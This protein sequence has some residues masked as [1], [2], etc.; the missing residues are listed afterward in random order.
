MDKD[1]ELMLAPGGTMMSPDE[2]ERLKRT[3]GDLA[4]RPGLLG[5]LLF[6][7]RGPTPHDA[8]PRSPQGPGFTGSPRSP[9]G[10][11]GPGGP[12][13]PWP[14]EQQWQRGTRSFIEAMERLKKTSIR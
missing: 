6:P 5:G 11:I 14:S 2:R 8:S 7:D 4:P 12:R 9:Q 1:L 10:P 13:D 3:L